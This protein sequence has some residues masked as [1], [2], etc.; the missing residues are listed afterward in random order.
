LLTGFL[1]DRSKRYWAW[2]IG[3]YAVNLLAVPALALAPGLGWVWACGLIVVERFGKA[4]RHPAK[5]T[6]ASFA[7]KEVGAGKGFALQ[8]ALD[9]I[10]AFLGPV[11]L[12]IVLTEKA[13]H[14]LADYALGFMILGIPAVITLVLILVAR[15]TYPRPQDFETAAPSSVPDRHFPTSY[16]IFLGA[17][18]FLAVGF[19]DFPLMAFHFAQKH[20]V[21]QNDIPLLYA[22]AM[23][24]DAL[25]ALFFGRMYDKRGFRALVISSLVSAFF[26]PFVFLVNTPWSAFLGMIFWG[27][28]MGAQESILKSAVT[29]LVPKEKR[30]T[31]FGIFYTGFGIF[32]FLG[33]W[34][35]GV[36]YGISLTSLVAFS[37]VFQLA[38]VPLFLWAGRHRPSSTIAPTPGQH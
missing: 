9:Q 25:S 29:S 28:G 11:L 7:A 20:T 37:M 1:S 3:G 27:V 6:L 30:G 13:G 10:G 33:S 35:M 18:A 8:E 22:L 32:W 36:L 14:T 5:N 26:A 4:I 24:V 17:I 34:A 21:P 12:F 19:A 38:S 2:T 16:W 15:F 31:A 23:G